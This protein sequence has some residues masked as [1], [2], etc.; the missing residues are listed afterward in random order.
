MRIFNNT[1]KE[2]ITLL[3]KENK[4]LEEERNRLLAKLHEIEQ[5]KETYEKLIDEA[6]I[7]KEKY[8]NLTVNTERI[9]EEYKGKLENVIGTR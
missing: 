4:R 8:E 9:F 7:V 3:Q 5:Y 6:K 2:T 1:D